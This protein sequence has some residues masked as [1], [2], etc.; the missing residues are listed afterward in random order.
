MRIGLRGA[1]MARFVGDVSDVGETS[2]FTLLS[3]DIILFG[4]SGGITLNQTNETA[5]IH[6]SDISVSEPVMLEIDEITR[7]YGPVQEFVGDLSGTPD[8]TR[9]LIEIADLLANI[10]PAAGPAGPI[11]PEGGSDPTVVLT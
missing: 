5:L 3:G 8:D 7:L 9:D 11:N 2:R 1:E 10:A 6:S 4:N